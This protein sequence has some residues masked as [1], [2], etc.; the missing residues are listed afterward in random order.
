MDELFDYAVRCRRYLHENPETNF[1]LP[2]TVA[3]VCGELERAGIDYTTKYGK[4]SV[5]AEVGPQDAEMLALRADMDALPVEEKTGLPFASKTPGKMHACGHDSHTAVLLAVARA[6]KSREKELRH[7]IRFIFQPSE[8]G[9]VSGAKM[10][11][12]NGVLEGVSTVICTHC[13][14]P[15]QTGY[16]GVR[17]GDYMAACVPLTLEFFGKTCHATMPDGGINAIAM[18]H[19]AYTR[20][21]QA[22]GQLAEDRPYIWSV[23][24]FQGGTAH[25]VIADYCKMDISFRFY[26]MEFCRRVHEK[27]EQICGDIAQRYGGSYKHNW[28]VSTV[29]VHNDR[30]TTE[31]FTRILSEHGFA[32]KT[33]DRR[34]SSE[35]F[36][37]FLQ[38]VPGMIFRFGTGTKGH[39][40]PHQNDFVL[41]EAGMKTAIDAFVTFALNQ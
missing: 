33:M 18:A 3:F 1:D 35:D 32:L 37:W 14:N 2:K 25:N 10:M 15:L 36:G 40:K 22:V 31:A 9:P 11:L 21:E 20:L 27:L 38:A 7:R 6:L 12:D 17:A 8:E 4:G 26:D 39:G 28:H 41:D 29:A 13:E 24:T 5:V 23:G 30:A 34:M 19:E 16:I